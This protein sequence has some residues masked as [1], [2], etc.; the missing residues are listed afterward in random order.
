M[1]NPIKLS[2]CIATLNRGAFIG[3]TLES[4]FNQITDEVEVV[5]VDGASTDNT[6]EVVECFRAKYPHLKYMRLDKKG[7][8]DQDYCKAVELARG[9]YVWLFTDDDLLK[10]GAVAGVLKETRNHYSLIIV[11]AEV[12]NLDLSRLIVTQRMEGHANKVYTPSATH[13]DQL[14]VDT[15]VYL[16]F[17]GAVVIKRDLWNQREKTKYFGL[18]FIHIGVIFQS[19]MPAD[20]LVMAK[21]WIII[22]YG[23]AQWVS[24]WFEIWMFNWPNLIWSFP[25]FSERAKQKIVQREPWRSYP[26]L[27]L[28]RALGYYGL[29]EYRVWISSRSKSSI[30]KLLSLAIAAIPARPLNYLARFYVQYIMRKVPS[31]AMEDLNVYRKQNTIN[32]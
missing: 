25:D 29:K 17:I 1:M 28:A 23:N 9:D 22:R 16:S 18:S 6:Q 14:L 21:P 8:V 7:G 19:P 3:Q 5:I 32:R 12:R 31:I 2:I 4:I 15:G 20:S 26:Q 24:R 27:L 30:G 11:N 13:Q 10:P